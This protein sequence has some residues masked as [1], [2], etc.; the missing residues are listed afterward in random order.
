MLAGRLRPEKCLI[1][2][3]IFLP[4]RAGRGI[5]LLSHIAVSCVLRHSRASR[6]GG[7]GRVR[8][9]PVRE[10][11]I[12]PRRPHVVAASRLARSDVDFVRA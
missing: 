9:S 11:K 12:C 7:A 4:A 10:S 5:L 3:D 1:N 6:C 2:V 8:S